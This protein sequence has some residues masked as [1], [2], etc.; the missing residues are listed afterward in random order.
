MVEKAKLQPNNYIILGESA[1]GHLSL[2][3]GYQ[4]PEQIKKIISLSGPTD[5][6]TKNYL[7]SFYSKYSSP[8]IQKMVGKKFDR[9]NLPEEFQL[10][11]PI[12]HVSNVPTLMFQGN[13]DFLV[14]QT[15][16]KTLDSVLE[17]NNIEHKLVYLDKSG[18]LT[19]FFSKK[20]RDQIIYPNI[21]DWIKK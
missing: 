3:Y 10:A 8:T 7:S 9:N 17:K 14:N 15:Q 18:H 2:L 5:F 13:R 16:A 4:H 21:L 1:G 6:Y 19:R 20:K 11:S 12:Y